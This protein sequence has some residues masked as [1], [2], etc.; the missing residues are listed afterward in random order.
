MKTDISTQY[1]FITDDIQL[2]I[3]NNLLYRCSEK[4]SIAI[5]SDAWKIITRIDGITPSH[6]IY[7]EL[8]K[9]YQIDKESFYSFMNELNKRRIISYSQKATYKPFVSVDYSFPE[10]VSLILTDRCNLR[11][12]Y[13]YGNYEP[14]L[15]SFLPIIR[16][17]EL[18]EQL[19]NV[20][21]R[22]L[23][24][25]GG[26]PLTHPNFTEILELACESFDYI[27]IMTNGSLFRK[28]LYDVISRY[29]KKIGV[30]ISVDGMTDTTNDL[31]R[32]VRGTKKRTFEA[33][34]RLK[35]LD[36]NV[37]ITYMM[38]Y[39]NRLELD[40]F[41][42]YMKKLGI[43]TLMISAPEDIGR[44]N[45][46]T[47]P[48]GKG[49]SDRSSKYYREM[50]EIYTNISRKYSDLMRFSNEKHINPNL[51]LLPNCG[52]GWKNVSIFHNGDVQAC[53]LVT[54]TVKLGN[55]FHQSVKSIFMNNEIVEFFNSIRLSPTN[56][57]K[58]V[59]CKYASFCG[60]CII[61]IMIANKRRIDNDQNI[62]DTAINN[63]ITKDII[64]KYM[65][66]AN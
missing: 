43:K 25:T 22:V 38:L 31:I 10:V 65:S 11:C 49:I 50:V 45:Y 44:G 9:H 34:E 55:F 62:C 18:I 5:K 39:E 53:Q 32:Q 14:I 26:E 48:D 57:K 16:A 47:F 21:V 7:E 28:E 27:S 8:T 24:L 58:C 66:N 12:N 59:D 2:N 61:K 42:A 3:K 4:K 36:I 19:K 40:D 54:N 30:R 51:H 20:G 41:C 46:Q 63:N 13:C 64:N 17:K 15:N 52:A 23:E 56:S 1:P 29:N 33:I 6:S 35:N 37:G 60:K